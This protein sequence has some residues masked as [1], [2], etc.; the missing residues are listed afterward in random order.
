MFQDWGTAVDISVFHGRREELTQ[1][2]SCIIQ[3]SCRLVAVVGMGGVGKTTLVTHLAQQIQDEFDYIF[4]RA[5]PTIPTND[6]IITDMLSFFSH[7]QESKPDINRLIHYLRTHRCLIILDNL[8]TALDA[9][10]TEYNNFLRIIAET[11]HESC[12]IFTSRVKPPQVKLLENWSLSVRC[13]RLLGSSEIALSLLQSQQLLGTEQQKYQLCNL[14]SNNPLKIQI[15]SHT[16]IDLFDGNIATFLAHNTLLIS[17]QIKILLEQQLSS[18]STLEQQIIYY[19]ATHQQPVAI[20]YLINKLPHTS[21]SHLF[22]AIEN[23]YSR[24]LIEKTAGKYIL[25][26]LIIEYVQ[27]NFYQTLDPFINLS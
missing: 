15:V 21:I 6:S 3:D 26:P 20:N 18:L 4:W 24:C 7:R 13:L 10:D 12:V 8:E 19:L 9:G 17:N 23:L 27:N 22:Q 2:E 11:K 1:L 16:I 14:Y 5:V 25:E